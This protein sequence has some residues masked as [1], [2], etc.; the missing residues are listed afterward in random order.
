MIGIIIF[1]IVLIVLYAGIIYAGVSE[2]KRITP[3]PSPINHTLLLLNKLYLFSNVDY[4][5]TFNIEVQLTS[6]EKLPLGEYKFEVS[7]LDISFTIEEEKN[8]LDIFDIEIKIN[9][10]FETSG[11]KILEFVKIS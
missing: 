2:S 5:E 8:H 10:R 1:I 9:G 4:D 3:T 11:D 7:D 6:T